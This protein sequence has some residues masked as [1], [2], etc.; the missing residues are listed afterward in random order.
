MR[1][2]RKT[3]DW[4]VDQDG[5]D[6]TIPSLAIRRRLEQDAKLESVEPGGEG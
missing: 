3:K 5:N 1:K 4:S 2:L 6:I